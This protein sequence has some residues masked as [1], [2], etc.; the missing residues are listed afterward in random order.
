MF[1]AIRLETLTFFAFC[2]GAAESVVL[3]TKHSV[4]ANAG[5]ARIGRMV[6][7]VRSFQDRGVWTFA[8]NH[9]VRFAASLTLKC[10]Q[11]P[12]G[13]QFALTHRDKRFAKF[14]LGVHLYPE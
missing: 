6:V 4:N 5:D 8:D 13:G 12:V 10:E 14:H 2:F 7:S 1:V 11:G 9:V 3:R